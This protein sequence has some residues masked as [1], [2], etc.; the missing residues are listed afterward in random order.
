[1]G[2]PSHWSAENYSGVGT[3]F[4]S[5]TVAGSS[6]PALAIRADVKEVHAVFEDTGA[7]LDQSCSHMEGARMKATFRVLVLKQLCR[8]SI[9]GV[10]V[11]LPNLHAEDR[12]V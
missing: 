7:S 12:R 10:V 8:S 5:T 1:M 4:L 3:A 2:A 11:G 6:L 9:L